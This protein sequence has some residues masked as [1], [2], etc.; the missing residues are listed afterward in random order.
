MF[1]PQQERPGRHEKDF[2]QYASEASSVRR[3]GGDSRADGEGMPCD[4]GMQEIRSV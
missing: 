4:N 1:A 2:H 3:Q